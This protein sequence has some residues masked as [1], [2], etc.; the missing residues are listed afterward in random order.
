MA[1]KYDWPLDH[2]SYLM[3]AKDVVVRLRNHP[4][5]IMYGGGN[6]LLPIPPETN[7]DQSNGPGTSPPRD[8]DNGLRTYISS[9]DGSR[10][11]VSSSVTDIGDAFDPERSLGPK[12]GPYGMLNEKVF[13]DRNPGLTSPLLRDE[14]ANNNLSPSDTDDK[15]S[16]GRNIG[17]QTEIGSVSHPELQSLKR[18]LSEE[19][20]DA[21]PD[22]GVIDEHSKS[23]HQEWSYFKHLPFAEND[24]R[25]DHICQFQFPPVTDISSNTRMDTIEDYTWA[26]QLAQYF[27]YK[28][29]FEGYLLRMFEHNSAVFLWKSS[30]PAP[31]LRGALYD[32]YLETNGGYWG[33]RAGVGIG[34]V[35]VVLNLQDWTLH[36]VNSAPTKITTSLLRWRAFSLDGKSVKSGGMT[37]PN[38][39][40]EGNFVTDIKLPMDNTP[41]SISWLGGNITSVAQDLNLQDVLIYRFELSYKQLNSDT[42]M[43]ATNSYFLTDPNMNDWHNRQSKYALLGALRKSYPKMQVTA[44]CTKRSL[45]SHI[46]CELKNA[47]DRVAIMV[48]VSLIKYQ[49]DLAS[50]NVENRVLPTYFSTNYVTLLPNES[51]DVQVSTIGEEILCSDGY[52]VPSKSPGSRLILSFDGWNVQDGIA[53]ISCDG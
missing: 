6:E 13:F 14:E 41:V 30:S 46:D 42:S 15:D 31:T 9:L 52:V 51:T 34:A 37:V 3:N 24:S 18:F 2:N 21:F 23:V 47:G 36:V 53:Q 17:F 11:Y 8:I 19:A 45:G 12:D 44:S 50:S 29:L 26:A 28:A 39:E 16:A 35:K 25:I 1:G 4:S 32:W 10:S 38:G 33:A 22:C 49:N 40:V 7:T 5:L 20:I 27:Q 48:K 43:K